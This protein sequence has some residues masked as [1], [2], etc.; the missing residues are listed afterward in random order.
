MRIYETQ[1]VEK[2]IVTSII[3]N[4]CGKEFK[5]TTEFY[6]G[7][8][9]CHHFEIKFGYGSKFDGW[10]QSFDLCDACMIKFIKSFNLPPLSI[11]HL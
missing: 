9:N 1:T 3:C 8:D 7:F 6:P 11:I 10:T 5:N 2:D 4:K